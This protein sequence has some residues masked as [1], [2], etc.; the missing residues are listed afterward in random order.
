MRPL[1]RTVPHL[2]ALSAVAASLLTAPTASAA[3]T[4][5]KCRTDKSGGWT[6]QLCVSDP[7]QRAEATAKVTRVK[8]G[9]CSG[10]TL[11]FMLSTVN[12]QGRNSFESKKVGC[13]KGTSKLSI[14]FK[15]GNGGHWVTGAELSLRK[16]GSYVKRWDSPAITNFTKN[17]AGGN[18]YL[19]R[20]FGPNWGVGNAALTYHPTD[21]YKA[22]LSVGLRPSDGKK[23]YIQIRPW[24][25]MD[26]KDQTTGH[27]VWRDLWSK[28]RWTRHEVRNLGLDVRKTWRKWDMYTY[29]GLQFRV[30]YHKPGQTDSCG[31]DSY[32]YPR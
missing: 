21:K 26:G 11:W 17:N 10:R 13:G 31:G 18:S 8:G 24:I 25:K 3:P 7:G 28:E 19:V 20:D 29:S 4:G 27:F 30:C 23:V 15:D 2:I 14:P 1:A 6:V 16:G 5:A 32:M 12:W 9:A 22:T